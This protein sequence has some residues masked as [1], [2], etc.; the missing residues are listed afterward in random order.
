MSPFRATSTVPLKLPSLD[1]RCMIAAIKGIAGSCRSIWVRD[2]V[3]VAKRKRKVTALEIF[4][5]CL[6]IGYQ[7][8][9]SP[10][11]ERDPVRRASL[12]RNQDDYKAATLISISEQA[13]P[14]DMRQ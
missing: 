13:V 7:C 9:D 12:T 6:L 2:T 11:P 3:G 8:L 4:N 5:R 14:G 1:Q 10:R